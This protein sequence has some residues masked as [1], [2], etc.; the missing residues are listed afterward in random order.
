MTLYKLQITTDKKFAFTRPA[1][2]KVSKAGSR[3][4]FMSFSRAYVLELFDIKSE[5]RLPIL[6]YLLLRRLS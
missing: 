4:H 1:K 5:Q 2:N 3:N 6:V